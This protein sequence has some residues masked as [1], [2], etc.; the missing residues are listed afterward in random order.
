M[1]FFFY[2]NFLP[3][4]HSSSM[5]IWELFYFFLFLKFILTEY[6]DENE[7]KWLNLR[8]VRERESFSFVNSFNF[9]YF[10]KASSSSINLLSYSIAIYLQ[11]KLK[12]WNNFIQFSHRIFYDVFLESFEILQNFPNFLNFL[13]WFLFPDSDAV[14]LNIQQFILFIILKFFIFLVYSLYSQFFFLLFFFSSSSS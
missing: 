6:C 8:G 3:F 4:P 13:F 12:R 5:S 11:H 9:F 7:M 14:S 2:L 1:I 10:S